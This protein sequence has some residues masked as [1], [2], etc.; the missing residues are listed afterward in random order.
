MNEGTDGE[1]TSAADQEPDRSLEGLRCL[2]L[3]GGGFIGT[4]LSRELARRRAS[5]TVFSRSLRFPS[6]FARGV[7]TRTGVMSDLDAL[8]A[9]V[10]DQDI[11]FHLVGGSV[12]GS[13]DAEF[14]AEVSD[15]VLPTLDLLKFARAAGTRKIIFLSSGGT[16]YGMPASFQIPETAP[17]YPISAYG[18]NKIAIEKY[19]MRESHLHRTGF[20]IFRAANVYGCYQ[21]AGKRNQGLVAATIERALRGQPIEIWGTGQAVRDFVHIDDVVSALVQGI[22]YD[23]PHRIMNVGSGTG[24]GVNEVV[25]DIE[26]VLGHGTLSKSYQPDRPAGV[27]SNVLD[28]A[29]ITREMKWQPRISWTDGLADTIEWMKNAIRISD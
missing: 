23:G 11:I 12:P 7:V 17:T 15:V 19:V 26:R 16:V 22:F 24:R 13:V 20:H 21:R 4:N 27:P 8:A 28:I 2:V 25:A 18:T 5:V 10:A 1:N 9:A 29:L 6:A 14:L 3:G